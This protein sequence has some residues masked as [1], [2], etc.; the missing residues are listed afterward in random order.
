MSGTALALVLTAA[1]VHSGWNALAKRAGNP[2]AFLWS[3]V[4]LATLI[5]LPLSAGFL[6]DG[7]PASAVPYVIGTIVIHA[8]YFYA[9]GRA[10]GSG[11]FSLVY[12]I[13]RGLGVGLVPVGALL[14]LGEHLSP[15]GA[16]GV[17]LVVI[18]IVLANVAAGGFRRQPGGGVGKGTGWAVVTG[19][20]IAT[21]SLVD[22]VGVTTLHPLPYLALMGAGIS[23][24]L[25]PS[26][27]R[28]AALRHEWRINWPTILVAA[29]LNLTSY[30]LVL[31][32][33]RLSK[34]AYVV[35]A[36]ETSIV[37]SVLIGGIWFGEGRL[38]R[39]LAAAGVVL[40]GVACVAL[41]R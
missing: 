27:W 9:L 23:V 30:L 11:D 24:L 5:F 16:T 6:R 38:A 29:C 10:L 28:A 4:T 40:A 33:F 36:R 3:S 37:F 1:L 25:L 20:T 21:Y 8:A 2:L 19:V 17:G 22:K 26:V 7:L 12:P 34:A 13:A 15:L 41:A 31:F 35:A 14:W 32:A 39:R 18:G